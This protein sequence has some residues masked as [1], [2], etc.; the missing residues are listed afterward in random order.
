M[1]QGLSESDADP[2]SVSME[3]AWNAISQR[4]AIL[5]RTV[6]IPV[7][8]AKGRVVS[9]NVVSPISVPPFRASAMDGF[10]YRHSEGDA[11]LTIS[12]TSLAGHPSRDTAK[13]NECHRV[14]TG[15]R[16]PD[17]ADTVVQLE[18]V[19]ETGNTIRINKH[20]AAG[21]HVR[22]PGSDSEQGTALMQRGQRIGAAQLA[23]LF[24]HGISSVNVF[25]PIQIA[26]FSTG[27]ELCEP[28]NALQSGQIYESNRALISALLASPA[29][30]VL[31]L[32][33]VKD[34]K[35]ALGQAFENAMGADI[36]VSSGGVSVG[37]ADFVRPVLEQYGELH[38]WK[39]AMK[40]GRPLTFGVLNE[41]TPF[42]GLPGN[43]VSSAITCLMFVLPAVQAM[44]GME[45]SAKPRIQA[46]L[47]SDLKKLPGRVEYQRGRLYQAQN[48]DWHVETTGMQDSHVITSLSRANCLIE[49]RLNSAGASAGEV[50]DTLP[51]ELFSDSRL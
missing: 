42:F 17:F 34:S 51:F 20:N 18:N 50:V 27:D 16:V 19:Q 23:T 30:N 28:G 25:E 9:D 47:K 3:S 15:A 26:V 1:K 46:K 2:N 32:G 45:I 41:Q 13:E 10:A 31:D 49:L 43:P 5:Q 22:G 33:I 48:G 7:A 44:L 39:I 14:M 38:V 36:I 29:V 11:V 21:F 24:S 8:E 4:L 40:P 12:D 37:D 6:T 35:E